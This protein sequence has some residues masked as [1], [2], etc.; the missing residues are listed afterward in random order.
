MTIQGF[1]VNIS[2]RR[3]YQVYKEVCSAC[4]SMDKVAFRDLV[5]VTHLE[6]EAKTIAAEYE[7]Q[8]GPNDQGEMFSRPGKVFFYFINSYPITFLVLIRINKQRERP[9]MVFIIKQ[10]SISTRFK[11]YC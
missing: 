10:R 11:L 6:N 8:D 4:H 9:I 2:L 5:G 7:Y 1:L 3:G